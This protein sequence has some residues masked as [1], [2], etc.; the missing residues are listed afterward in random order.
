MQNENI[1]KNQKSISL[2]DL[3]YVLI[4]H[5]WLVIV[6]TFVSG[7]LVVLLLLTTIKLPPD[8]KWN[9]LPNYYKPRAEL[10]I[11]QSDDSI[12]S[13]LSSS[14]GSPLSIITGVQRNPELEL[15]KK[16]LDGNTIRD[17][18]IDEYNFVEKYDFEDKTYPLISAR[19]IFEDSLEFVQ[20]DVGGA[21][22]ASNIF[23]LRYEDIDPLFAKNVLSRIVEL[24]EERYKALTMERITQKKSFIEERLRTVENELKVAQEDLVNFQITY[25]VVDI[26]NQSR[27][28]AELIEGI[29]SE[30][31]KD[32]L[33]IQALREYL[34]Q[35][36]PKIIRLEQEI[37]NK[38]QF[39]SELKTGLNRYSGEF[40]PQD[41]IPSLNT[42]YLELK[43][44]L[45]I[46]QSIYKM[47]RNEYEAVKIQENDN[48]RTFQVI[49]A[50]ELLLVKTGPKRSV[51]CMIM[52]LAVFFISIFIA[53]FKEYIER[54]KKD[55]V[56]STKLDK[57]KKDISGK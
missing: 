11:Q 19:E 29:Q 10:L 56:E 40:I 53:F 46:K 22:G 32:E 23:S 18:I 41:Q 39:I 43:N 37:R 7:V 31:I 27:E 57:I 15:A 34:P 35:N 8:H 44:E 30:I 2:L 21:A 20:S 33:E 14:G 49:E 52:T 54:V 13:R 51:I 26:S 25:G 42:R 50:P 28:Q 55:P 1:K 17:K 9:L 3:F 5:R 48:S 16:L 6:S 24:L 47:L 36:D 4:K 12:L 38:N 45:D